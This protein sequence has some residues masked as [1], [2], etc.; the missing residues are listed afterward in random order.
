M[1]IR[2][3][4]GRTLKLANGVELRVPL[5]VYA[6]LRQERPEVEE[7]I[8]LLKRVRWS[9]EWATQM[10]RISFGDEWAQLSEEERE[11][12]IENWLRKLVEAGVVE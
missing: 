9:R 11:R 2:I 12:C 5:R 8:E 10:C 3:G 7:K 6:I 4:L 1:R